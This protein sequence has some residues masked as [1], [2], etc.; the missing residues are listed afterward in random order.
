[1]EK[2]KLAPWIEKLA[3]EAD[4]KKRNA[5]VGELCKENGLNI[6]DAWK[7]LKEAGF[8]PKAVKDGAAGDDDTTASDKTPPPEDGKGEQKTSIV[9]RHKTPYRLYRRAGIVLTQKPQTYELTD[10]QIAVMKADRWIE[11]GDGGEAE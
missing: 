2:E 9:L 6:R 8:D 3:A 4:G 11:V 5:I 1:M 10:G 7:M